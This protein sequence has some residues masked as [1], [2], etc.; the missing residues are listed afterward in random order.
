MRA[1]TG[2]QGG[3]PPSSCAPAMA[4]AASFTARDRPEANGLRKPDRTDETAAAIASGAGR[5]ST[6]T[7]KA[8]GQAGIRG[9]AARPRPMPAIPGDRATGSA[10]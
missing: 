9:Q 1:G 2:M 8:P 3:L 7:R 5:G 4:A 10:P 6:S